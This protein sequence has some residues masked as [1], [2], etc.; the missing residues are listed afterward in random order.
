MPEYKTPGVYVVEK[1][2]LPPS[3]SGVSTAIPAFIGVPAE[4]P[5]DQ[6]NALNNALSAGAGFVNPVMKISSLLEYTDSFGKYSKL[7]VVD[8]KLTGDQYNL[9]DQIRLFYANGGDE[10][11]IVPVVKDLSDEKTDYTKDNCLTGQKGQDYQNA[12]NALEK[13]DEVTLLVLPDVYSVI[14]EDEAYSVLNAA[15]DHCGKMKDRFVILDVKDTGK[16]E[17]DIQLFRDKINSS[18]VMYAAAYY[19]FVKTSWK[20]DLDFDLVAPLVSEDLVE[21]Y[22]WDNILAQ[23]VVDK[24]PAAAAVASDEEKITAAKAAIAAAL[25]AEDDASLDDATKSLL[26]AIKDYESKKDYNRKKFIDSTISKD[27]EY[28]TYAQK[29]SDIQNKLA[30]VPPSGAIAGI[31]AAVDGSKGVW[32]APANVGV[33]SVSS[34]N[35]FI[36]D[37]DQ[38]KMNVHTLGKSIN[39]IRFFSGKGIMVW[40]ARTLDGSSQEWRYIPVRRLFNYIEESIQESTAWA[41]FQ[42]NDANTWIKL[43]CQIDNFLTNLWKDGALA[44]TTPEEAFFVQVGRGTSMTETDILD[45]YLKINIGIAAVRPA[46]FIVLTFTHKVQ[47]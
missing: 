29:Y 16:V 19:P 44:G 20:R 26:E 21:R 30:T 39:A 11:Y 10:C 17:A 23:L 2:T 25:K 4:L 12:I 1:S 22:T 31:Y 15:V 5:A 38:A 28:A 45:G 9:Y 47:E 3:V 18:D 14:S 37:D 24:V 7:E 32:Q 42:P 8:G 13:I 34:V 33:L 46:E 41:V 40:G 6:L 43:K 36:S 27:A 35:T